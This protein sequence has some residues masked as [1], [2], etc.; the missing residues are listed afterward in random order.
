MSQTIEMRRLGSFARVTKRFFSGSAPPAGVDKVG[1]FVFSSITLLGLG[2]GVWQLQRYGEKVEKIKNTK[3]K[4]ESEILSLRG[5]CQTN[6]YIE[7]N[8][9]PNRR[10]DLGVGKFDHDNEVLLGLRTG[11]TGKSGQKAQGM[12]TNPQV[13]N[14]DH[15]FVILMYIAAD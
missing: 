5:K 9:V 14:S 11:P 13:S 8:A 1:V 10:V 6:L 12:A 2:L 15:A 3:T 4:L 7:L